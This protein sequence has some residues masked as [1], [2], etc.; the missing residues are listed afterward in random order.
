MRRI[1]KIIIHC[2]ATP[3]HMDIGV[4]EIDAWH[5][6]RGFK[7]CGYHYV[8]RKNGEIQRGRED[9]EIGAHV[10]GYNAKSIGICLVGG[11]DKNNK[12]KDTRT[13]EQT[14]SLKALV[15]RLLSTYEGAEVLGHRDLNK[16]KECPCFDVKEWFSGI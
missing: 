7:G 14:E 10:K 13:K 16:N 9:A 5:K 15:F 6:Q 1:E 8:I 2:S 3:P 12:A 4:S 11:L